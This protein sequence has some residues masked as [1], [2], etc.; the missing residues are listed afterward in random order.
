MS[1][2]KK[3]QDFMLKN[4]DA[5]EILEY[6]DVFDFLMDDRR[7]EILKC[8]EIILMKISLK[9]KYVHI[10][11]D[12]DKPLCCHINPKTEFLKKESFFL[13]RMEGFI[14][15]RMSD[16]YIKKGIKLKYIPNYTP[17]SDPN[18]DSMVFDHQGFSGDNFQNGRTPSIIG[19]SEELKMMMDL[20]K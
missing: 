16:I 18:I 5:L 15:E 9:E 13:T 11:Y 10:F 20:L 2:P 12:K 4:R 1:T 3:Q 8:D 6:F 17:Y 7:E 14:D 19:K